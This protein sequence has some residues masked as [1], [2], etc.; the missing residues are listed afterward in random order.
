[1]YH[2]RTRLGFRALRA[3]NEGWL[4]PGCSYGEHPHADVEILTYTLDGM[5]KHKDSLGHVALAGR[6]QVQYLSAG[7]GVI[8]NEINPS[9]TTTTH[10]LQVWILPER[11]GLPPHYETREFP[12]DGR[13]SAWRLIGGPR[14]AKGA[15]PIHQDVEAFVAVLAPDTP[16]AH[17]FKADRHGWVQLLRGNAHANGTL[18]QAGD[19]ASISAEQTLTI[20][21][22][23]RAEL[24]LF[25][26][27]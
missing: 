20:V 16:L 4:S 26:L 9:G 13:E 14:P 3:I 11:P 1:D 7:R 25:D 12:R 21:A 10:F 2:D 22:S 5:L 19:G 18:L 23:Q 27:A 15:G 6:G 8:H 24:V 17:T